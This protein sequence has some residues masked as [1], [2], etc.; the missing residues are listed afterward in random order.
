MS[1]L[2]SAFDLPIAG[3]YAN[4]GDKSAILPVVYG[5]FSAEGFIGPIPAVLIDKTN[6]VYAAAAHAVGS[7]TDVY[8][9][10]VLQTSGYTVS[11]SNNY[12]SLGTIAII[13][14][15]SQPDGEVTWRGTG[16]QSGGATIT[17]PITQLEDLLTTYGGF[18]ASDFD[19]AA[20][21]I[22][23]EACVQLGYEF[24]WT[25]GDSRT[26]LEWINDFIFNIGALWRLTGDAK[27]QIMVDTG[28]VSVAGVA[29]HIYA[30]RDCLDGDDGVTMVGA[31]AEM[32]N[33]LLIR[34]AYSWPHRRPTAEVEVTDGISYNGH[35]IL[36]HTGGGRKSVLLTGHRTEAQVETWAN[37][38]LRRQSYR[39]RVEGAELSF[40]VTG[41]RA[42]HLSVGDVIGFSW[43]SGPTRER[44]MPY[45]NELL[46]VISV[47]ND[48]LD[49]GGRTH[50]EAWDT[51]AYITTLSEGYYDAEE[52]FDADVIFGADRELE[53]L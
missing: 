43:D 26:A 16:K 37:I 33:Q 39:R 49:H 31:L 2:V 22:A 9:G 23:R 7:I 21:E 13:D 35:G 32:A 47:T 12:E 48:S 41:S 8:V 24:A 1:H 40:T 45:R 5:G 27:L 50:I 4:P 11:I 52:Y 19:G 44:S 34:Y 20:L 25:I 10:P 15:A 28:E 18:L 36:G 51:G 17:N 3:R 38:M 53:Y 6:W 14:F 29:A 46:Q 42:A 30:S